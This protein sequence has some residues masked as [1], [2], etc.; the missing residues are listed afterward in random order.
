MELS[1]PTSL[2][3]FP[4]RGSGEGG[5]KAGLGNNSYNNTLVRAQEFDLQLPK[6]AVVSGLR[7]INYLEY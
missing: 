6:M 4:D 3:W 1:S 2:V 5:G 7:K